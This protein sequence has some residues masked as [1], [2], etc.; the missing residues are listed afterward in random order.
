MKP[1]KSYKLRKECLKGDLSVLNMGLGEPKY[2]QMN[3]GESKWAQVNLGGPKWAQVRQ[4]SQVGLGGPSEP[5]CA[6]YA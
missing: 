4:M 5:I 1:C 6:T 2:A 3:L